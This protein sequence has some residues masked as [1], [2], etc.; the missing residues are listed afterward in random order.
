MN[1]ITAFILAAALTL[2]LPALATHDG[3]EGSACKRHNDHREQA[4]TNKDGSI[5]K[6]EAQAMHDKHFDEMDKNKDGKLSK[7]EAAACKQDHMHD[8]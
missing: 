5:D 4:D 1:K 2:S 8:K 3:S 6:S 7:E